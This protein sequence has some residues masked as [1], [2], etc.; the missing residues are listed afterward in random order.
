M[1]KQEYLELSAIA[2]RAATS[3]QGVPCKS[4]HG[5]LPSTSDPNQ[6][7]KYTAI[8]IRESHVPPVH[9]RNRSCCSSCNKLNPFSVWPVWMLTSARNSRTSAT[10]FGISCLSADYFGVCLSTASRSSGWRASRVVGF[11]RYRLVPIYANPVSAPLSRR[12]KPSHRDIKPWM[13]DQ[14]AR[15]YLDKLCERRI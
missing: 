3:F 12:R 5:P 4:S 15:T 11:I 7:Y 10:T 2:L 14:K 6:E 13:V 9:G 8:N 1:V